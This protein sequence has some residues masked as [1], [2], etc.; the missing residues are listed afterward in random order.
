MRNFNLL[1]GGDMDSGL[2][3]VRARNMLVVG[4]DIPQAIVPIARD[5]QVCR[6]YNMV[7]L[8]DLVMGG[9]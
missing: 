6:R 1:P 8:E 2:Q 3:Q 9:F 5:G 4:V 7:V